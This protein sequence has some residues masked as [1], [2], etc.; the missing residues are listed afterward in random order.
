MPWSY[1]PAFGQSQYQS[2]I[3][4]RYFGYAIWT[5]LVVHDPSRQLTVHW[6]HFGLFERF[7]RLSKKHGHGAL[8]RR[9]LIQFD[10]L[11][12]SLLGAA[13]GQV[14]WH[15]RLLHHQN[16]PTFTAGPSVRQRIV[17]ICYSRCTLLVTSL[18]W[19]WHLLKS[20]ETASVFPE[21]SEEDTEAVE[22]DFISAALKQGIWRFYHPIII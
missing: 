7:D 1:L 18:V 16:C 10:P 5:W 3:R 8:S 9:I 21:R 19:G 13:T 11:A 12:W 4:D 17:T 14:W 20:P 2:H 15:P 22:G 6:Q